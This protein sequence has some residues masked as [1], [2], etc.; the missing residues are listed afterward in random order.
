MEFV[1]PIDS[2]QV[3]CHE[4]R[5]MRSCQFNRERFLAVR[6]YSPSVTMSASCRTGR[7]VSD[8]EARVIVERR[9][10]AFQFSL[11][12]LALQLQVGIASSHLNAWSLFSH[13]HVYRASGPSA[14]WR[15]DIEAQHRAVVHLLMRGLICSSLRLF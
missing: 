10:K 9:Q 2:W 6:L 14:E 11:Q 7:R 4:I 3:N 5:N 1:S 13:L 12:Q 15:T 8:T